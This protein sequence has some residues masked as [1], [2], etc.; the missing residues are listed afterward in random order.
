MKNLVE[1]VLPS[2]KYRHRASARNS[3]G[4]LTKQLGL[5]AVT[6]SLIAD[7]KELHEEF[8][9]RIQRTQVKIETRTLI[10]TTRLKFK[11][12][13]ALFEARA[14]RRSCGRTKPV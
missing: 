4:K 8:D 14:K 1:D 11:E 5:Q 3:T 6:T 9:L 2:V 12:L 10:D 7:T 13:L